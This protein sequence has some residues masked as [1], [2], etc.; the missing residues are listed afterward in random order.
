MELRSFYTWR[1][2]I[3]GSNEKWQTWHGDVGGT[4][5]RCKLRP[6]R[7]NWQH[8]CPAI[9][10]FN[11]FQ[12]QPVCYSYYSFLFS[13][14]TLMN[15]SEESRITSMHLDGKPWTR[16]GDNSLKYAENPPRFFSV[17]RDHMRYHEISFPPYQPHLESLQV[18][19]F[20]LPRCFV[21]KCQFSS[22]SWA[23]RIPCHKVWGPRPQG[24]LQD[25]MLTCLW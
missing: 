1:T 22:V 13:S 20:N 10:H 9:S 4:N 23:P 25:K 21:L 7:T 11:P 18:S 3:W 17:C 14:R 8:L 5:A 19:G 12:T 2:R 16:N 15:I 6:L 24:R